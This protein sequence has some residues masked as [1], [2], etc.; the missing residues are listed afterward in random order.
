[1]DFIKQL[2]ASSLAVRGLTV[3]CGV[4]L[5]IGTAMSDPGEFPATAQPQPP[6]SGI[7]DRVKGWLPWSTKAPGTER[8]ERLGDRVFDKV[9]KSVDVADKIFDRIEG[10]IAPPKSDPSNAPS[11]SR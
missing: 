2:W 11:Q 6:K 7:M 1:M 8:M 3:V 4:A 10:K 5:A 9:E